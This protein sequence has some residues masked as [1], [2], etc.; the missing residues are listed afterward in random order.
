MSI[1]KI[2]KEK[3]LHLLLVFIFFDYNI[4]R[5]LGYLGNRLPF[6]I[7]NFG[8]NSFYV[9]VFLMV[10]LLG[11]YIIPRRRKDF[12][13]VISFLFF[14][15]FYYFYAM[16]IS[17][18]SLEVDLSGFSLIKLMTYF[19]VI[20]IAFMHDID[21]DLLLRWLVNATR[22]LSP[23]VFLTFYTDYT[24]SGYTYSGYNMVLGYQAALCAIVLLYSLTSTERFKLF[25]IIDIVELVVMVMVSTFGGSRG[26]VLTILVYVLAHVFK[27]MVLDRNLSTKI[28]YIFLS[29]LVAYLFLKHSADLLEGVSALLKRLNIN[30][31]TV[32]FLAAKDI[33][34]DT[35]RNIKMETCFNSWRNMPLLGYGLLGDR[36]FLNGTYVHNFAIETITDFGFFVGSIVIVYIFKGIILAFKDGPAYSFLLIL[37]SYEISHLMVSGTYL[38]STLFFVIVGV[39]F[40]MSLKK[41]S[42]NAINPTQEV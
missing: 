20:V 34:N 16:I 36:Q 22:I 10:A 12:I 41:E 8:D 25:R 3:L 2:N 37:V 40:S 23:V 5:T 28:I 26:S 32:D 24:R 17:P 42:A 39:L 21:Y 15:L 30:S 6:R 18:K 27:K 31:R 33:L 11:S 9:I 13:V 35:N 14:F 7:S 1:R 29:V 19:L 4:Q 38:T